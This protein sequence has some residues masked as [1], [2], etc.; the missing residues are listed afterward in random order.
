MSS[1][2]AYRS[3]DKEIGLVAVTYNLKQNTWIFWGWRN[4]I[5]SKLF[6]SWF[7]ALTQRLL[8]LFS[9]F[10]WPGDV[11][12]HERLSSCIFSPNSRSKQCLIQGWLSWGSWTFAAVLFHCAE[13]CCSAF[14]SYHHTMTQVGM[15]PCFSDWTRLSQQVAQ[16]IS[17]RLTTVL[18]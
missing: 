4:C 12:T 7:L 5:F 8:P 13:W 3:K 16:G 1:E 10:W 2:G 15:D 18:L 17:P 14:Y 11:P 9:W 6:S